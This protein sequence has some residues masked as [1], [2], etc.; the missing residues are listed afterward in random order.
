[1]ASARA[2]G[3]GPRKTGE[4]PRPFHGYLFKILAAQ[5]GH[6]PG[7]PYSYIING[8][9]IAGFALVAH[10]VRWGDSGIMTFIVNQQG[11]VYQCNLGPDTAAKVAGMI[12]FDPDPSWTPVPPPGGQ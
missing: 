5:G 10:P 11:K 6:A 1:V 3:Y 4:A 9:M 7:G 2:E 8:N 12:L